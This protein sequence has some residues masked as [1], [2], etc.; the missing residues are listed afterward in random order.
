MSYPVG[1]A[2]EILSKFETG[3]PSTASGILLSAF[4]FALYFGCILGC[5]FFGI[6]HAALRFVLWRSHCSPWNYARFL[7]FASELRF[8]QRVGGRYRFIH[9]L[10]REHFA[11][12]S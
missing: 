6:R 12:L 4:A 8:I 10:L 1:L 3:E 7:E 2:A 9:D 5:G 11:E